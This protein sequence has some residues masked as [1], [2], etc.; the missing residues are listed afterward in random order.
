[1]NNDTQQLVSEFE[2]NYPNSFTLALWSSLAARI[3]PEL[4][5]GLRLVFLPRSDAG[6]EAD[7]WFSP[8][9]QSYTT[10]EISFYPAVIAELHSRLEKLRLKGSENFDANL[11]TA[12]MVIK[13]THQ[14][15]PSWIK[16]EEKITYL[17]FSSKPNRKAEIRSLFESILRTMAEDRTRD[18]DFARWAVKALP[19][20]PSFVKNTEPYQVV[21]LAASGLLGGR[22]ILETLD[23]DFLPVHQ[24]L[25]A[26]IFQN[27]GR[28]QVNTRF[29]IDGIEFSTTTLSHSIVF[30]L[31]RTD[32][33][34]FHLSW[35]ENQVPH[36]VSVN[37]QGSEIRKITLLPS[38]VSIRTLSGEWLEI[39]PS[40]VSRVVPLGIN[41]ST[42]K[43][44]LDPI[45]VESFGENII[46]SYKDNAADLE[47]LQRALGGATKR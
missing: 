17:S 43:L 47:D 28:V 44:L 31:P 4:L 5:R 29:T 10:A 35:H 3:E 24:S 13:G 15:A 9:V 33:L 26:K 36:D 22:R 46:S 32:P 38:K 16:M 37:L 40:S 19:Q 14:L 11:E 34:S 7:L 12:N 18:R 20:M 30:E 2:L 41:Y 39:G 23:F 27:I 42:R 6:S 1:M 45:E 25:L 8:L 21:G